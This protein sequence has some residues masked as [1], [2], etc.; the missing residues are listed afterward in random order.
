MGTVTSRK[1]SVAQDGKNR[2]KVNNRNEEET[3]VPEQE[4]IRA[5]NGVTLR[6]HN[7]ETVTTASV[8]VSKSSKGSRDSRLSK[9]TSFYEMVDASELCPYLLVG[10]QACIENGEFLNRKRVLFVLNVS[11]L[12]IPLIK[13]EIEY[14]SIPLEDEDDQDLLAQLDECL[15]FLHNARKKCESMK[16]RILIY[17]YFGLSRSCSVALAHMMKEEEWTLHKSW[18]YLK[19]C[20]PSAQPNDGF[21]LQLLQYE[22]KLHGSMSMTMQ[23]FYTR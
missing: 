23:D 10:N 15:T 1:S 13:K 5:R 7:R 17:S 14:K 4:D 8:R 21:L 11:N 19:Q 18:S 6:Q 3:T 12:A 22:G 20:H 9:H 16:C 2:R